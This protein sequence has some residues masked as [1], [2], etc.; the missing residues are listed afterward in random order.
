MAQGTHNLRDGFL[1]GLNEI[2]EGILKVDHG[3]GVVIDTLEG[4]E[5][6]DFGGVVSE[7]FGGCYDGGKR[8]GSKGGAGSRSGA[9]GGGGE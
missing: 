5:W 4:T 8:C 9:G 3:L 7:I 6:E 2:K 1:V